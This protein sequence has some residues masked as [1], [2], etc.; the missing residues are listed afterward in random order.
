M[1]RE[2]IKFVNIIAN[3]QQV[4]VA[5][6]EQLV[7]A[8]SFL[9]EIKSRNIA[10]TNAILDNLLKM[11]PQY[12]N[13]AVMDKTGYVWGTASPFAGKVSLAD[14]KYFKNAVR[15]GKF[16]TGEFTV[17]RISKK[18]IIN[19]GYPV[20]NTANRLIAVIGVALDLEYI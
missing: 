18:P 6:A 10:A 7:T 13:I 20:K 19:F 17:G 16:S 2:S 5:G 9:P 3:E 15:T 11:N 14:R 4:L 12:T 1:Q 8:L